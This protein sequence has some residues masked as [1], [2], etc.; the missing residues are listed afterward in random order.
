MISIARSLPRQLSQVGQCFSVSMRASGK[1]QV[2]KRK[3]FIEAYFF[4]FK[5]FNTGQRNFFS[6][7]YFGIES[8]K[9]YSNTIEK[10]HGQNSCNFKLI[11]SN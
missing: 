6:P 10:E 9:N 7:S 4:E 2:L 1:F 5:L 11:R 3:K 8:F